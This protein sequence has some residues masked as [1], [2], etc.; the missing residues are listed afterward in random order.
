MRTKKNDIANN[1]DRLNA[2][3]EGSKIV[4][5]MVTASNLRI[6]GEVI[7]NI[8][9][10]SKIVIGKN[11]SVQGEIVCADADIEG[12]V[13]GIIKVDNLLALKSTSKIS[14]EINAGKLFIEEGA[15]FD[16]TC[17]MGN[18]QSVSKQ[19]SKQEGIVY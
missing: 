14:G 16:G 11:G 8:S 17:V 9:C 15:M 5:D 3:M 6:D 4:G 1:P 10:P 2:I 12:E 19:S 18:S 7:G 13:V